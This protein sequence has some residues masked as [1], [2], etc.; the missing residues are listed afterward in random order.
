MH[1]QLCRNSVEKEP[2]SDFLRRLKHFEL[3]EYDEDGYAMCVAFPVPQLKKLFE[4]L[5]PEDER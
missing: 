3:R 1:S 4:L 2:L 5:L